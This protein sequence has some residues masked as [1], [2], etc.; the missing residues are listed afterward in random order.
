MRVGLAGLEALEDLSD[1]IHVQVSVNFIDD[2]GNTVIQGNVYLGQQVEHPLGPAR[3][4]EQGN[5][6]IE[7]P[8]FKQD[9][10]LSRSVPCDSDI[11]DCYIVALNFLYDPFFYIGVLH[12]QFHYCFDRQ[13]PVL[14]IHDVG[15]S[16]HMVQIFRNLHD[17]RHIEHGERTYY[18]GIF[19]NCLQA[20]VPGRNSEIAGYIDRFTGPAPLENTA[21]TT[22][23][24]VVKGLM[25]Y[26]VGI[27]GNLIAE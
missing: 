9:L 7:S 25:Q 6:R 16:E 4:A 22:L 18:R 14:V 11:L 13:H 23:G 27:S 8:V 26:L 24:K 5:R 17:Q 1:N 12:K 2:G 3:F 21:Q 10:L 20:V 19:P 15:S